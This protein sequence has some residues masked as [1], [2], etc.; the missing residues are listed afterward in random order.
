MKPC[1]SH[2]WQ[3]WRPGGVQGGLGVEH[4]FAFT[5]KLRQTSSTGYQ[6]LMDAFRIRRANPL[7]FWMN[8]SLSHFFLLPQSRDKILLWK[9]FV[10]CS[11]IEN[12]AVIQSW[13]WLDWVISHVS[14]PK[15]CAFCD[16]GTWLP[17]VLGFSYFQFLGFY[18]LC[19][20]VSWVYFLSRLLP[21][22]AGRGT[23]PKFTVGPFCLTSLYVLD[24]PLVGF[25]VLLLNHFII[26]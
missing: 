5:P 26:S 16:L 7:S 8:G 3:L 2:A 17:C 9:G 23:L 24:N 12:G 13:G 10:K 1:G 25:C 18:L 21:W 22:I 20:T 19:R 14:C 15:S 6:K 11:D 4:I